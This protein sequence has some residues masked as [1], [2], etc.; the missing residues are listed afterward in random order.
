MIAHINE[1]VDNL[2]HVPVSGVGRDVCAPFLL[3][4][5][6]YI[7]LCIP[8]QGTVAAPPWHSKSPSLP[9]SGSYRKLRMVASQSKDL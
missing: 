4:L 5:R 6:S 7:G 3:G 1:L 8:Q 9:K 2:H